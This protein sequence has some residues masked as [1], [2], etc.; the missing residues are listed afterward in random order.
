MGGGRR[1]VNQFGRTVAGAVNVGWANG[2]TRA[3]INAA[4]MQA[5]AG[6][7]AAPPEMDTLPTVPSDLKVTV[8]W[9]TGSSGPRQARAEGSAAPS[10]P[11]MAPMEGLRGTLPGAGRVESAVAA[12]DAVGL[13]VTP[14]ACCMRVCRLLSLAVAVAVAVGMFATSA[15]SVVGATAGA[16]FG[17]GGM[18]GFAA[19]G[20]AGSPVGWAPAAGRVDG[21]T[22]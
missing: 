2:A 3:F 17:A 19:S 5:S 21:S 7:P 20:P 16:G 1:F 8:A 22:P 15:G 12:A 14:A 10:A 18:A 6:L 9:D 4:R 11:W 13:E